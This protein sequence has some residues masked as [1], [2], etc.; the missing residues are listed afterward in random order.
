MLVAEGDDPSRLKL[1]H[2]LMLSGLVA[3]LLGLFQFTRGKG[4]EA[5]Y[6]GGVGIA[7]VLG[8]LAWV[9]LRDREDRAA[10]VT[11]T[12]PRRNQAVMIRATAVI[13]IGLGMILAI[14]NAWR[15]D[16]PAGAVRVNR[17]NKGGDA[18]APPL[19]F[20]VPDGKGWQDVTSE[21]RERLA[22]RPGRKEGNFVLLSLSRPASAGQDYG[23]GLVFMAERLP[24]SERIQTGSE[25]LRRMLT[26]LQKRQD[27]PRDVREESPTRISKR[28]YERLSLKRPLG[29]G[30]LGMTFWAA[31]NEGYALV[32][33]GSY[34]TPEG[35]S[36]IETLLGQVFEVKAKWTRGTSFRQS[37]R[38][39]EV[40]FAIRSNL[41]KNGAAHKKRR[42]SSTFG[43]KSLWEVAR[44]RGK[45]SSSEAQA[46]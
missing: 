17:V 5:L 46:G 6:T 32:I 41:R 21:A 2:A 15:G 43:E 37:A 3:M 14:V 30:E 44:K 28:L 42:E 38:R 20:R 23:A 1:G 18:P 40:R 19:G 10:S 36:A 26:G 24:P 34:A 8:R 33:T 12:G 45:D 29:D 35:L 11:A 16:E 39:T 27:A 13:V 4:A 9:T 22:E 31:V 25:Y 7:L